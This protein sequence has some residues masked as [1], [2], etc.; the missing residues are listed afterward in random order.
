MEYLQDRVHG[1]HR[2]GVKELMLAEVKN[3]SGRIGIFQVLTLSKCFATSVAPSVCINDMSMN[4]KCLDVDAKTP[5]CLARPE[6]SERQTRYDLELD[7]IK[8]E[9]K[10]RA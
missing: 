3:A 8:E 4:E 7:I 5:Y 6:S 10:T 9:R 1:I 2:G